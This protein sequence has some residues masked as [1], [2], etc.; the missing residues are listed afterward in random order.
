VITPDEA[1]KLIGADRLPVSVRPVFLELGY[2]IELNRDLK[3]PAVSWPDQRL[4]RFRPGREESK[5][6]ALAHELG[7]CCSGHPGSGRWC[8]AR[9]WESPDWTEREAHHWAEDFLMPI[10][11]LEP[12]IISL[13]PGMRLSRLAELCRVTD[14]FARRRLRRADLDALVWDDTTPGHV[15]KAR[16]APMFGLNL[17]PSPDAA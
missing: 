5:R 17:G 12:W 15:R 7:H 1:H 8:G 9:A 13:G 10:H 6:E 16:G 4:V 3:R 2:S 11:L 14:T